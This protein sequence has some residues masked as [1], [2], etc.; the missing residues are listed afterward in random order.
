MAAI[1][2]LGYYLTLVTKR[3]I[4]LY[5]IAMEKKKKEKKIPTNKP[6]HKQGEIQVPNEKEQ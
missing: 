5:T 4:I 6:L 1:V 2:L 3:K